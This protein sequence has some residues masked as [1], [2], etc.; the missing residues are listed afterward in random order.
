MYVNTSLSTHCYTVD[1]E[2][3]SSNVVLFNVAERVDVVDVG[4][5]EHPLRPST[6]HDLSCR[7]FDV[8]WTDPADLI[9]LTAGFPRSSFLERRRKQMRQRQ[10]QQVARG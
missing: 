1:R 3:C 6:Q 8:D 4:T 10:R 2:S 9:I 7:S 5:V